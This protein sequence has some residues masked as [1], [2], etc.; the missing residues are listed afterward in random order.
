MTQEISFP[1]VEEQLIQLLR[2]GLKRHPRQRNTAFSSDAE[3]IAIAPK[4]YLAATTDSLQEEIQLGVVSNPWT[5]GWLSVVINLSDLAAVAADPLGILLSWTI[6]A[7]LPP[8]T[9]Q[10][11]SKGVADAVRSHHT[12]VLGGDLN[13]GSSLQICGTALGMLRNAHPRQRLGLRPGHVVFL[14]GPMGLGNALGFAKLR[15]LPEAASIESR[16]RPKARLDC[17]QIIRQYA[18]CCIDTSDGVLAAIDVLCRLNRCG[19]V[20]SHRPSSYHRE[21]RRLAKQYQLPLWLFAAAEQGEFE[22]MFSVPPHRA[23]ACQ[24]ACAA[25]GVSLIEIGECVER[26]VVELRFRTSGIPIDVAAVRGLTTLLATDPPSYV[27]S[28]IRY[29]NDMLPSA[30]RSQV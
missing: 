12:H 15:N 20:F 4:T 13:S 16:F 3:L 14:T 25:R 10:A 26:E 1:T 30:E 19:M 9:V 6:P 5:I 11:I 23:K 18:S 28:L 24:R 22:L 2:R 17:R 21:A 7:R 29:A 27:D 8:S